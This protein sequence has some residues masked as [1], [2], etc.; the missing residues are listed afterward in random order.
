MEHFLPLNV[1]YIVAKGPIIISVLLC[2]SWPNPITN[3]CITLTFFSHKSDHH[4]LTS[5]SSKVN[6]FEQLR[7]NFLLES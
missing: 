6:K 4:I 3:I 7:L 2:R 5:K 1:L